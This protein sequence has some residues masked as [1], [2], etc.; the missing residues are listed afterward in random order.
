MVADRPL[1]E[2]QKR[3]CVVK[4]ISNV[5][6]CNNL[7]GL[8]AGQTSINMIMYPFMKKETMELR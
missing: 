2:H 3:V 5:W 7:D 1:L 4:P 8:K 6:M